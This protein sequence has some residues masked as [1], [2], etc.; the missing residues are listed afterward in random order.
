MPIL[1][2]T[3]ILAVTAMALEPHVF[4]EGLAASGL[5]RAG[6]SM[7]RTDPVEA[8]IVAGTFAQPADGSPIG[9]T[10]WKRAE[11][12]A[13]GN[14]P[15][16]AI[17]EGY[18]FTTYDAPEAGTLLLEAY[19]HGM[20]Y[21]NGEPLAG[22][23]YSAP[24]YSVP[25]RLK[26]G[27]NTFLFA[28]G[29]GLSAR[30]VPPPS[31][32]FISEHDATLPHLVPG[33][34][35]EQLGAVLLINTL[36][37]PVNAALSSEFRGGPP[38]PAPVTIILPPRSI[39]KH[40]FSLPRGTPATDA[41]DADRSTLRVSIAPTMHGAFNPHSRE[42]RIERR[43]VGRTRDLTFRSGIDGSV[44]YYSIVPPVGFANDSMRRW[45]LVLSLH[46]ADVEAH[47]QAGAYAP[48]SWCAIACPT[49][50]RRF[51]FDWE[52]W[53]RLDAFEVLEQ[54]RAEFNA[55]PRRIYLT[56]HSMGGHGTWQLGVHEPDAF[57]AIAPSAG[58]DSFWSYR[59]RRPEPGTP[60]AAVLR[61]SGNDSDTSALLGNLVETGVAILHGDADDNVPVRE[62]RVMRDKLRALGIEPVY[63]EQPGAGH[64]WESSDEPGAECLDWPAFFDLFARTR[65]P[66]ARE[67]R[68]VRLTTFN[69]GVTASRAWATIIAQEASFLPST[70]DLQA[71]PHSR[72]IVGATTNVHRL[73]LRADPLI[74]TGGP[75]TVVLD[76]Q[77]V[78]LPMV[79]ESGE[80]QLRKVQGAWA[81]SGPDPKGKTPARAGPFKAAFNR[82]FLLVRGTKGTPEETAWAEALTRYHAQ[83][84]WI[85]GN[86]GAEII[87]DAQWLEQPDPSRNV[88][89][90]GHADM[91]AAWEALREDCPVSV[92][93]GGL[94]VGE[95][96]IAAED[97][98]VYLAFP[99]RGTEVG[100]AGLIAPTGEAG[101]RLAVRAGIFTSGVGIPDFLAIDSS[102]PAAGEVGIVGAGFFG[103]DWDVESGRFGWRPTP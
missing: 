30:L 103:P 70:I 26:Q 74:G 91:N 51:G 60:A 49:N 15:R 16:E 2:P 14:F 37:E 94:S 102:L 65:L 93:R 6:R 39:G 23:P 72:R 53:G 75:L 86:G 36:E 96:S 33:E 101:A 66:E 27:P 81:L 95:R 31:T 19:G 90:Y 84:W 59:G 35:R 8:S 46:G 9:T 85:R 12:G 79:A 99:M 76:G 13:D 97:I 77:I 54:A 45:P 25:V 5:I 7:I 83:T 88:I 92:R 18:L 20:V 47:S 24:Y 82:R 80:T 50:R 48:K 42:F 78:H 3:A 100:L 1:L 98:C 21:V 22:N 63:H 44:Q 73:L 41:D 87:T 57:A 4:R 64:W 55:N 34:T 40:S 38:D 28:S 61:D 67:V 29:R 56:G 43:A 10:T 32:V 62:A 69:P 11:A 17:S 52:D 71:E 68:R 58:W 89:L